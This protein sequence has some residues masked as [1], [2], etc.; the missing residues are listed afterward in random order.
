MVFFNTAILILIGCADF[1]EF[2]NWIGKYFHGKYNDYS[3]DWF[4]EVGDVI[5]MSMAIN[6][7]VPIIEYVIEITLNWFQVRYD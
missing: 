7:F 1:S 4:V 3:V 5:V 2:G 6:C